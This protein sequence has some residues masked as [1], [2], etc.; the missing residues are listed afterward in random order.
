MT[1][2]RLKEFAII[3]FGCLVYALGF[4]CFFPPNNLAYGGVMGVILIF[5]YILGGIPVGT[6]NIIA[7][8]PLFLAGGKL[9]GRELFIKSIYTMTMSSIFIDLS[10]YFYTFGP[11]DSIL[12]SIYGG[13]AVGVGLGIIFTQGSSNGGSD[14]LS[15]IIRIKLK[16]ATVAQIMFAIDFLVLVSFAVVVG[17]I[18]NALYGLM[19]M[20][21]SAHVIDNI[22]YGMDKS[23]VAYIISP[24]H[25]EVAQ[26]LIHKLKRGVTII[27]A[28]G[29]WSGAP[30]YV[31]ICA[32]KQRQIVTIKEL[33]READP[34]AFFISCAAREVAGSGFKT[35]D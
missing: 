16:W 35:R 19:A 26:V 1:Q 27:P 23:Q 3:T 7:N 6:I 17:N 28:V 34:N 12:A 32:Y 24:K 21:V 30:Q 11:M 10:S 14:L 2:K 9:L 15:R 33:V 18:N 25:E 29:G 22:M 4:N 5:D 20:Y 13:I 31:I 8:V